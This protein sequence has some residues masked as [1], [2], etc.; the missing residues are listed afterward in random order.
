MAT[1]C[2]RP[3]NPAGDA[4][5]PPRRSDDPPSPSAE[6]TSSGEIGIVA[7]DNALPRDDRREHASLSAQ[8]TGRDIGLSRKPAD[9]LTNEPRTSHGLTTEYASIPTIANYPVLAEVPSGKDEDGVATC[10]GMLGSGQS[11]RSSAP[12]DDHTLEVE[13]NAGSHP[14]SA[15]LDPLRRNIRDTLNSTPEDFC[16]LPETRLSL[17]FLVEWRA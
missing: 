2:T 13:I 11:L 17:P 14:S 1:S 6:G 7:H 16:S 10:P 15:P 5:S 8:F 12:R 4:G 3:R 9:S